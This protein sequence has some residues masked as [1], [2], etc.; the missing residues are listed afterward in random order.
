MS[1]ALSP[2]RPRDPRTDAAILSAAQEVLVEDGYS[3]LTFDAVA[4]R[5]GVTRPTIYRRWPSRLHLA[6]E[7]AFR[8]DDGA[9][10]TDT[11]N[12]QADLDALVRASVAS[13]SRPATR[14]AMPGILAEFQRNPETRA[15]LREPH[16]SEV[17]ARFS[18]VVAGAVARG[19]VSADVDSDVLFDTIVGAIQFRLIVAERPDDAFVKGLTELVQRG[20]RPAESDRT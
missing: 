13:Y 3:G 2:G 14:A 15:Q 5:A 8:D 7:A 4:R 18:A 19:E 16:E 1:N 9:A 20:T 10:V 17:R 11:G 12:F 6:Y